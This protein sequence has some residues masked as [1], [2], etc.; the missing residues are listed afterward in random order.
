MNE[1]PARAIETGR[2]YVA[3]LVFVVY[4]FVA[5]RAWA[6]LAGG[7]GVAAAGPLFW[8]IRLAFDTVVL[9]GCLALTYRLIHRVGRLP[10]VQGILVATSLTRYEF[11]GR[12]RLTAIL[13]QAKREGTAP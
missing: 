6:G 2:G 4:A 1:C 5:D 10:G 8:W 13:R 11:W 12:Y 7:A 9:L 3:A